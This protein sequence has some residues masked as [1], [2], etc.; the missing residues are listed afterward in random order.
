M[1]DSGAAGAGAAAGKFTRGLATQ[2]GIAIL[3]G[4]AAVAQ[5]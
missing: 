1:A 3:L 5:W 4:I 2:A